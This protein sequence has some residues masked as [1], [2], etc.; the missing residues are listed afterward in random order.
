ME[1]TIIAMTI[2]THLKIFFAVLTNPVFTG[3]FGDVSI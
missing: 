1:I 2:M 3:G